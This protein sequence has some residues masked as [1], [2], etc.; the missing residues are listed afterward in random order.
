MNQTTDKYAKQVAW[1]EELKK[2]TTK[3]HIVGAWVAVIFNLVFGA[4]DYINIR[5]HFEIFFLFR[6]C[7][8]ALTAILLALRKPLGISANFMIFVPFLLISI[9]NSFMWS[10]MDADLLQKHT[11]AYIALFIGAGMLVLWRIYWSII[12]VVLSIMANVIFLA[13]N[14]KLGIEDILASGGL[15]TGTVMIFSILLIQ[16]RYRLTKNEIIARLSLHES[17]KELNRQKSI[18][19]EKNKAITAS[20][21]YAERI[22]KALLPSEQVLNSH[23][24]N[25]LIFYKPRDIVSGDFYWFRHIDGISYIAAVDCTGHGVPGA[26]MSMIGHTLLNKYTALKSNPAEILNEMRKEVIETLTTNKNFVQSDGMDLAFCIIDHEKKKLQFAGA[27]NPLVILRHD[28]LIEVKADR[29]PIG[30]YMGKEKNSFNTK[31]IDLEKHDMLYMFS[32]GFQDQIGEEAELKYSSRKFKE[33]LQS[34]HAKSFEAQHEILEKEI[35]KWRGKEEQ[36]DDMLILGLK[37]EPLNN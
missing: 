15:L 27:F 23:F 18:V 14:S 22:Q 8:S 5:E 20:I 19:E 13:L 35:I 12:V 11:L 32:D 25:N 6:L 37:F 31:E 21:K 4:T 28:E 7:V 1:E 29:M 10:L 33:L 17:N 26:F 9:Q 24:P 30:S 3:Y 36:L 34:I 2:S 16:T